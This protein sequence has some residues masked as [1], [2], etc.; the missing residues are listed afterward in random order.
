MTSTVL[1]GKVDRKR[2]HANVPRACSY[3]RVVPQ[4]SLGKG[5]HEKEGVLGPTV[6]E[7]IGPTTATGTPIAVSAST[8]TLS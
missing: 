8:G 2:I 7:C 3:R 4:G 6:S 5:E 1:P